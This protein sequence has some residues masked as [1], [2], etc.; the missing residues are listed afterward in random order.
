MSPL[1][2]LKWP[3]QILKTKAKAVE[4]FDQDLEDFID[5]SNA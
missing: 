2:V 4:H 3:N 5:I 1:K